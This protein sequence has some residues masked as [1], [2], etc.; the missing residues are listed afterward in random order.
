MFDEHYFSHV[1]ER[2]MK[3]PRRRGRRCRKLS[4]EL[5]EKIDGTGIRKRKH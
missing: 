2:K 1:I 5:K 4:D 3:R